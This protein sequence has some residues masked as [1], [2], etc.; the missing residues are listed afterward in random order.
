MFFLYKTSQNNSLQAY[1][2]VYIEL[3]FSSLHQHE[4]ANKILSSNWILYL[5]QRAKLR[6]GNLFTDFLNGKNFSGIFLEV[7]SLYGNVSRI[8]LSLDDTSKKKVVMFLIHKG[9]EIS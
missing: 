5:E 2:V 9:S 8:P 3:S 4:C 1:H 7:V 6:R